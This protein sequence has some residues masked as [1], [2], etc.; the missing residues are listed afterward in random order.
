VL[1]QLRGR[2]PGLRPALL[3]PVLVLRVRVSRLVQRPWMK[4]LHL[5][6]CCWQLHR[7]HHLRRDRRVSLVGNRSFPGRLV[8]QRLAPARPWRP[9]VQGQLELGRLV[10]RLGR[11]AHLRTCCWQLLGPRRELERGPPSV[12]ELVQHE[13]LELGRVRHERPGQPQREQ[14]ELVPVR[15]VR[16][17]PGLVQHEQLELGRVR[18]E[19]PGQ[20]QREQLELVPVRHVRLEPG[21]REQLELRHEMQPGLVRWNIRQLASLLVQHKQRQAPTTTQRLTSCF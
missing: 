15:H 6:T 19:R 13:Q 17:E 20:L 2:Q 21:Q 5:R 12:L 10:R 3:V 16:L 8:Q 1:V 11:R 18:H 4:R 7:H 14:L 9:A